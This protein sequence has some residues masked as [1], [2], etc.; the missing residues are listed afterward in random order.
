VSEQ[1]TTLQ[2]DEIQSGSTWEEPKSEVADTDGTDE[3]GGGGGAGDQDSTDS[4]SDDTDSDADDT[5]A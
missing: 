2:D 3:G 5:D 1:D 4:D